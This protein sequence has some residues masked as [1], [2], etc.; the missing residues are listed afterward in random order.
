MFL[1]V[2]PKKGLIRFSRGGGKLAP[3]YIGPF[4]VLGRVGAVAYRLLAVGNV[5]NVFHVSQLSVPCRSTS[6][7][8]VGRR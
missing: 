4:E 2:S 8:S 6:R 7:H 1:R 5:H 3:R